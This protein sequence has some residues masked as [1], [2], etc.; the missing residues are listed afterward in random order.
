MTCA[1]LPLVVCDLLFQ[2]SKFRFLP[3]FFSTIASSSAASSAFRGECVSP[4]RPTTKSKKASMFV[5]EA[6]EE[7]VTRSTCSARAG[8]CGCEPI[9]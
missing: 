8:G 3:S 7:G 4:S 2:T 5:Y 9:D 6:G 1:T